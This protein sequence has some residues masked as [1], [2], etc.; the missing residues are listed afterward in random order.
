VLLKVVTTQSGSTTLETYTLAED[1]TM[2]VRVEQPERKPV[3]PV[4]QRK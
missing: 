2:L 4:F 3:T 1:G